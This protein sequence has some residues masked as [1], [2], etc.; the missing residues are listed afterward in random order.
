MASPLHIDT[1]TKSPIRITEDIQHILTLLRASIASEES[2]FS[3][4]Y[5]VRGDDLLATLLLRSVDHVEKISLLWKI[6]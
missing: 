5:E 3:E 6:L 1:N 4:S 2:L